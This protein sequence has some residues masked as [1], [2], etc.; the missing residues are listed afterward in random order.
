MRRLLV[1][2]I[3]AL[4]IAA[5]AAGAAVTI[6]GLDTTR[7]PLVRLTVAADSTTPG[8]PPGFVVTEN[9]REVG[10]LTVGA[11]S[12]A[13]AIVLAIDTSGSM[14]GAPIKEALAAAGEFLASVKQG[15]Q[16]AIVTFGHTAQVV[17]PLTADTAALATA[18]ANLTNDHTPGTALNDGA[19]LG[20]KE[21][22]S[23][24]VSA[25]R[26]LVVMT[27]GKDSSSVVTMKE[28][29][30]QAVD[31]EVAVYAIALRSTQF[32]P[33]VLQQL[34]GATGG[35]YRDAETGGLANVY[36]AVADELARTYVLS[37]RSSESERVEVSV[38]ADGIVAKSGY[39]AGAAPVVRTAKGIVP[40]RVTRST[41]SSFA[42]AAIVFA[43][44][45]GGLTMIFRPRP[46]RTLSKQLEG[47]TEF[48]RR[49]LEEDPNE[50]VALHVRL[51]RSTERVLGGLQFWKNT[52]LLIERADLPLRTGEVFYMQLGAALVLGAPAGFA[53]V[54]PLF[55][56]LLFALGFF[57]PV[58]WLK[59]KARKRQKAFGEQLPDTLIAMAA[60]LKAG[61]SWNQAMETVIR[62]GSEPTSREFGRVANE[63]R[64]GRPN[65]DAMQAMA[66]RLGS[67]DF[68]F[69][70]MS[71]NIQRQV[72][73]SLA[74]LLDQVG[75]TVR[76]RQQFR[77]KVKALCAMGRMSAYTLVALPFLM[78]GAI[79]ALSP[80]YLAPLWSTGTGYLLVFGAIT[81][82]AFGAL[83]LKKIVS[84][85][86]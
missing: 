32:S 23:A 6:R 54:F 55:T 4:A 48:S 78:A 11:P 82:I 16:V 45:C 85:K 41:W 27:D 36:R 42:L 53:G 76:Q 70:V 59:L 64:L 9:T 17:Q 71:V 49:N 40:E 5:P 46:Q 39:A 43:L 1:L 60:S 20:V 26:V 67:I 50:R 51:A 31:S 35:S 72:G 13:S 29:A 65:D 7:L 3:A 8:T 34:A 2:A 66:E 25:R 74:D 56:L 33:E 12:E 57:L 80:N 83:I 22:A 73:G 68:E 79:F 84:F 19:L 58:V 28:V 63:V 86:V 62:E 14:H 15:D 24:P 52:A 44:I 37:Y 30:Q 38:S 21:L 81:S 61:H 10:E 69:V 18:L 77:R 47:Y 75:E